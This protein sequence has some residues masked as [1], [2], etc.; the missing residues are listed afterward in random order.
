MGETSSKM[1]FCE[2][3]LANNWFEAK[4]VIE[5]DGRIACTVVYSKNAVEHQLVSVTIRLPAGSNRLRYKPSTIKGPEVENWGSSGSSE[6][7]SFIDEITPNGE[8][9]NDAHL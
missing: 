1:S 3:Q 4:Q 5:Q 8:E 2:V 9:Y 6:Q 7:L